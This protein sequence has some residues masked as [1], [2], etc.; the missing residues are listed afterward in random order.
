VHVRLA[1][2]LGYVVLAWGLAAARAISPMMAGCIGLG[3]ALLSIAFATAVTW[4][5]I[6]AAAVLLIGVGST[7]LMVLR[8]T[9]ADWEHTPQF[10]GFRAAPGTS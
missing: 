8:E 1:L 4:L 6:V 9:D 3:A 2:A 7:G 5:L 10:R